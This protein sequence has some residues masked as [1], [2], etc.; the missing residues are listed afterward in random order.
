MATKSPAAK[1]TS[2]KSLKPLPPLPNAGTVEVLPPVLPANINPLTGRERRLPIRDLTP[3]EVKERNDMAEAKKKEAAAIEEARK[4]KVGPAKLP[5]VTTPHGEFRKGSV[6]LGIYESWDLK[7]GSTKEET[8]DRLVKAHPDRSRED[9]LVTINTQIG[10]MPKDRGFKL[11]RTEKG[12]YGLHIEGYATNRILSPA[13]AAAKAARDAEK[14]KAAKLKA[15]EK[16]KAE[17][18]AEA[19]AKEAKAKEEAEEKA[20][21]EADKKKTEAANKTPPVKK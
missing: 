12:A 9:M 11:G 13:A 18:K 4:E 14:E 1:K 17:A 10:R 8:L 16:A 7:N 20:R 2:K 15:E 6:L 21:K 3:E 19:K 5:T